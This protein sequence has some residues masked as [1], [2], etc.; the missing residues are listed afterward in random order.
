MALFVAGLVASG[1]TAFPLLWEMKQLVQFLGL[2]DATSPGGHTGLARWALT[3]RFGL[4]QVY[5]EHPWMAYGTDWLAFGHLVIALFFIGPLIHPETGRSN[6]IAGLVA[7][8]GVIPLA[9]IAGDIRGVP[10]AS[11][12]IDC[13]FGLIGGLI[14]LYCF[15]LLPIIEAAA[16]AQK[17]QPV[18]GA[19]DC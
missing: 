5:A 9:L 8:A 7:C 1:V 16:A 18:A 19:A 2:G 10:L 12:L 11:R 17:N 14:L 13:A 15:R 4:E 6:I 3:V